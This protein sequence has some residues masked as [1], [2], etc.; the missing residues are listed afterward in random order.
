MDAQKIA[1]A[2]YVFAQ[3]TCASLEAMAMNTENAMLAQA[4]KPMLHGPD[5]FMALIEKYGIHHNA[6]MS[7]L[8][9][10]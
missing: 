4:G 8:Y 9:H 6:V 5:A 2:A 7:T 1:D 10:R 3:G